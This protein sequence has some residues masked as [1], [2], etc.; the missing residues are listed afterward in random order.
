[1]VRVPKIIPGSTTGTIP[2]IGAI[3]G[4]VF[5]PIGVCFITTSWTIHFIPVICLGI[6]ALI[7]DLET[8]NLTTIP[9]GVLTS[10][11]LV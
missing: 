1:M 7:T 8:P 3:S 2:D 5:N 11:I 10:G 9:A 4:G 6:V